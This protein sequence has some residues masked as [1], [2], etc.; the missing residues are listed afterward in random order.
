VPDHE[1][2]HVGAGDGQAAEQDAAGHSDGEED[3]LLADA[4][5]EYP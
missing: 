4:V 5:T 3:R 1:P 2:D